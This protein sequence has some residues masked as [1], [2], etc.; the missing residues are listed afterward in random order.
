MSLI[1]FGFGLCEERAKGDHFICTNDKN[2][3]YVVYCSI[4]SS[5]VH[6]VP[7]SGA[8]VIEQNFVLFFF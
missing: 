4:L 5:Y 6:S 7:S 8:Y 3:A 2:R 1:H